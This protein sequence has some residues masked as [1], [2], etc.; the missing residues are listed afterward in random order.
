MKGPMS[1]ISIKFLGATR[2][3]TGSCYL[4]D[5]GKSRLVVECGLYQERDLKDRNWEPFALDPSS[6][7][8]MLLTHGHLDHCGRIPKLCNEGFKG[9]IYCT[10]TTSEVAQI[11]L[12]DSAHIQEEDVKYK[13]KR[14]E[15][16]GRDGPHPLVPLYTMTDVE[17]CAKQFHGVAY[18]QPV[19]VCEDV[20]AEFLEAGHILGSAVIRVTVRTDKGETK[21]LFSGDIGRDDTPILRDPEPIAEAD[22]VLIE[23]T[24]GNRDHKDNSAIDE[25]LASLIRETVARGGK[26]IIPSFSV[27]RA[28]E[29]LYRLYK[30]RKTKQVPLV[31]VYLDSPMAIHIT[32]VLRKHDEILDEE[33]LAMVEGGENP[34]DFKGLECCVTTE[35]SKAINYRREPSIIIAGSGM[36]TGGR[37]KHHLA[38]YIGEPE[39]LILFVGYQAIGT[40]GRLIVDGKETVRIHGKERVVRAQVEKINGFSAH[41]DR[42]ELLAWLTSL[43]H[44]PKK[45]FVVHGE[46]EASDEFARMIREKTGGW[47]AVVPEYEE[48]FDLE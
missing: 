6:I 25:S 16:E 13:K 11:V 42:N 22:Y 4:L 29:L 46:F 26:I 18:S 24:Y 44:Q 10:E 17:Q 9:R 5:T 41:A 32:K 31:P 8:C 34:F 2:N 37:I 3:V 27:E 47:D 38:N 45:V 35:Q 12:M 19:D 7:D 15:R 14:H 43:K 39:H 30:L 1:N 40:L 21:I 36:C 23:S 48:V 20:T 28:Q 33:S